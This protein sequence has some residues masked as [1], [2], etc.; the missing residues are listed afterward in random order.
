MRQLVAALFVMLL[1]V[2]ALAIQ[3]G[4][5]LSDPD[6]EARAR[7]LMAELRCLVCQAESVEAS[8]SPFAAEVRTI[9][10]EQVAAGRS[11]GEIKQFLTARYGEEILY[12]PRWRPGT[13]VLWLGPFAALVIGAG[14]LM[15][16][17]RSARG[18]P[19]PDGLSAEEQSRLDEALKEQHPPGP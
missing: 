8:P 10:R 9:V 13:W 1:A 15:L 18:A 7:A 5:A 4:E 3:P 17:L 6:Q 16:V 14:V 11:D 12:R 2:P 19:E